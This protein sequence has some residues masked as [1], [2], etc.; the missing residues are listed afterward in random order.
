[1]IQHHRDT[2]SS[3]GQF[4]AAGSWLDMHFEMAKPEYEA[5][6]RSAGFQPG[7]R[8]LDAGCGSGSFLPLLAELVG[9]SGALAAVDLAPENV[10]TVRERLSAWNLA[11]PVEAEESSVLALPYP[12]DTFDGLWCAAVAQYLSDD[13]V[14]DAL[15][16]FRRVVRPGGVIAIKDFD[17]SLLRFPVRV[18][19]MIQ[20]LRE[21]RAR[22]GSAQAQGA[23]RGPDL[24]SILRRAELTDIGLCT[25]L[26][27]RWPPYQLAERR[28]LESLVN[29]FASLAED[30]DIAEE[31]RAEWARLRGLG[32]ALF[33]DPDH[34]YREGHVLARGIVPDEPRNNTPA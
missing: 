27:E 23:V 31:E 8:V 12:D 16:E 7:W 22:T 17:Q 30:V 21:A 32:E 11:V 6:V 13:E 14:L 19:G 1:M 24:L 34:Y 3:T 2:T 29:A 20:H 10:A 33:D 15:T 28:L 25:T 5:M 4:A 26:V 9:L 18:P